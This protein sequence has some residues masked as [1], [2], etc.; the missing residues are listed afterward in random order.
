[1]VWINLQVLKAEEWEKDHTQTKT[2]K[3]QSE[4]IT[5]GKKDPLP[6]K[7]SLAY[8]PSCL[9]NPPFPRNSRENL[10]SL[11]QLFLLLGAVS[12]P[13]LPQSLSQA[14]SAGNTRVENAHTEWTA[15]NS[16]P[17]KLLFPLLEGEGRALQASCEPDP[18]QS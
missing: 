6:R 5:K 1:M 3:K 17:T 18:A 2:E 14:P 15:E 13:V 8:K 7:R 11:P 12:P 16:L 10:L 9:T 4:Q